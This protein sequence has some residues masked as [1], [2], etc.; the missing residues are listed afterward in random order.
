MSEIR[1][2]LAET[3]NRLLADIVTAEMLTKAEQGDWPEALWRAV[4]DNGLTM[5]LVSEKNGGVGCDWLDAMVVLHGAGR[6]SAP[7]PLA[8][9]ILAS[10][11]LDRADLQPPMGPMS[12]ASGAENAELQFKAV[13]T[14]W[15]ISGTAER[16]PWGSTVEHL[17][18][19]APMAGELRVG[20]V[21]KGC[22]EVTSSQNMAKE[23]RDTLVFNNAPV[24]LVGVATGLPD[25]SGRL[26]GALLRAIQIG[27]ALER[28][29]HESVLYVN[30]RTQF[31]KPIGKFQA[32]QQNLAQLADEV[33]AVGAAG[34]AACAVIDMALKGQAEVDMVFRIAAAKARAS[35]AAGKAASIAHQAHGAFGFTYEHILHFSTR[36]LWSWR[37]EYGTGDFWAEKLGQQVVDIG[38]DNLWL[39]MTATD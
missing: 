35:E 23:P 7:I 10:W 34:T 26:F 28:S 18:V 38:A 12:F 22:F 21:K 4:E 27:G 24:E 13:G 6:Y 19:L 5:P 32:V 16:V 25:D 33:A 1:T 2:M 39:H 11:L 29:L 36:R 20:L 3:V 15:Q 8:E 31:G 17:V 37:A 14:N 30:D 9:T